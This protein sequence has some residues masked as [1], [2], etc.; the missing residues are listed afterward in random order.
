MYLHLAFSFGGATKIGEL[1]ANAMKKV[2]KES[3]ITIQDGKKL[4]N[5][6]EVVEG[7]ELDRSYISPYFITNHKS[8]KCELDDPL[9]SI[10]EKKISSLNAIIKVLELDLKIQRPI[11]IVAEDVEGDALATI[12]LN[13]LRA[14]IKVCAIKAPELGEKQEIKHAGPCCF[15]K[16]TCHNNC[17]Y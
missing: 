13:K 16:G 15:G 2:G 4:L 14:G 12:I 5:E 6:L 3:V 10:H 7:M 1:I 17:I 8:Q 11:L 9:I